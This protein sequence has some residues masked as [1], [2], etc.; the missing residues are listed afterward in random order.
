MEIEQRLGLYQLFLKLYEHHRSLLDEFL[1]L[2]SINNQSLPRIIPKYVAGIVQNQQVY[3]ITNLLNSK[4]QKLIQP[5]RVW[6]IG[7]GSY[8]ALSISDVRLSRSHAAIRYIDNEGFY[9][10][11]LNSTNGTFLNHKPI[12]ESILLVDG[13][14]IRLGSLTFS[15]FLCENAHNLGNV[16][17]NILAEVDK[18]N[19]AIK[20]PETVRKSLKTHRKN[21]NTKIPH[22]KISQPGELVSQG[23]NRKSTSI[24]NPKRELP[25]H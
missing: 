9:L 6:T 5:Q 2:E 3:L 12:R 19:F 8:S 14:L 17:P 13:D 23:S 24:L 4:S 22:S 16:P 7:R 20:N 25:L 1:Q 21:K 15:F 18:I 10:S 11:D